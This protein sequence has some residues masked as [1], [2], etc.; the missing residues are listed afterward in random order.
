MVTNV[1]RGINKD[2]SHETANCGNLLMLSMKGIVV[3]L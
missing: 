2:P 1:T 3:T